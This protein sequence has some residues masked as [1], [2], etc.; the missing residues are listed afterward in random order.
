MAQSGMKTSR[1][2]SPHLQV[3]RPLFTMMMSI[4]HRA[5]GIIL[6]LGTVFMVGWLLA[7]ASGPN[8]YDLAMAFFGSFIGYIVLIG[9]TWALM[10]HMLG[11]FRHFIWD[12]GRGFGDRERN[13]MARA[14]LIG[15]ISLT[16]LLW[17]V[18]LAVR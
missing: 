4:F 9:L 5:T 3:Y 8:A 6:Y 17:I 14:T 7:A 12:V 10:H 2:L 15:S 1:P 13:F 16:I 18:G 11:G